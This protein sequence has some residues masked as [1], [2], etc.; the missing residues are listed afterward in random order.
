MNTTPNNI[1]D[2]ALKSIP[3]KFR[4]KI[5]NSYSEI[6]T[7]A[8]TAFFNSTWDASGLSSGKFAETILRF[9]QHELTGTSIPFNRH[10]SNFADECRKIIVLPKTTGLETLRIIMPRA[11]VFLYTLR[12]KR[13]IGHVGGDIDANEIDIKTIVRICDWIIC[14][15]IRIY[16]NISLEEAQS[17]INS[18][19]EKMIPEVWEISGKK[20]SLKKGLNYKDKTLLLLYTEIENGVLTEDIFSWTKH[21]NTSNYKRD[22]LIPLHSDDLIE[23]DQE[24]EIIYI[25]PVGIDKVEREILNK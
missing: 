21:S 4:A 9:L 6:K 1:L 18:L 17:I 23:Y 14:E 2:Q 15:L 7:R 24:D 5:I 13:G 16:H 19:S 12:G 20:R 10:V 25:S 3:I 8:T 11:L 22:V